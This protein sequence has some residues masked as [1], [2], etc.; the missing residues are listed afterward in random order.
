[1]KGDTHMINKSKLTLVYEGKVINY[2]NGYKDHE[3]IAQGIFEEMDKALNMLYSETEGEYMNLLEFVVDTE[4]EKT[5][6]WHIKDN[7]EEF[8]LVYQK[9]DGKIYVSG[10]LKI[11]K[12]L[13]VYKKSC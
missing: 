3:D 8:D 10:N 9:E 13:G 2:A 5:W 7:D 6:I 11:I 12:K 4:T 1:M